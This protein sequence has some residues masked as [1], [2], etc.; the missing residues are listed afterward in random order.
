MVA[1]SI[2]D[3]LKPGPEQAQAIG[4]RSR[5]I[6]VTA[7]AGTGKTRT[8]VGRYLSLLEEG[9]GLSHIVAITF[10]LRAAREMRNRVREEV[11][12]HIEDRGDD[13]FWADIYEGLNAAHIGTIHS[14]CA[15]ILRRHPVEAGLDPGFSLLDDAEMAL[16]RER[17]VTAALGW[18]AE[19]PAAAALFDWYDE[20]RLRA[21]LSGAMA[22]NLDMRPALERLPCDLWAIWK[23]VLLAPFEAFVAHQDVQQ[24]MGVLQRAEQEGTLAHALAVA[25]KFADGVQ[26][27]LASWQEVHRALVHVTW[28]RFSRTCRSGARP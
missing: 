13:R 8:L 1:G 22:K 2:V 4:T 12:L 17:A 28:N 6:V 11:R 18:A 16:E 27:A 10:T 20:A 26:Q 14:L 7:G 3:R 24:A 25:D 9:V 21:L 19:D 5:D 15:E 23:P